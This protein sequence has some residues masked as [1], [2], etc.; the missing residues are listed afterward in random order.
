MHCPG[1][2]HASASFVPHLTRLKN[3]GTRRPCSIK[4]VGDKC[5]F[6]QPVQSASLAIV[7]G[8]LFQ[9][10]S[11]VLPFLALFNN[12]VETT[13][14]L[15]QDNTFMNATTQNATASASA[16]MKMPT[17]FSSL[18]AFIYSFSS[19]HDYAKLIVLGGAFETL[20]RLYAASYKSL[21][22][23]FFITATFESDDISYGEH[24]SPHPPVTELIQ[25]LEWMMFWLS[26]LPQFR[27]FRD[28]SVCTNSPSLED[29]AL[30]I[31]RDD[32]MDEALRRRTRP[33]Q[34][35]PSY[36]SSYWMWYKGTYIT[37][38]RTKEETRWYSEKATLEITSVCSVSIECLIP[39]SFLQ[40]LLP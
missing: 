10:T 3:H 6:F 34:Y 37:I 35:L 38:S 39:E 5:L 19:L 13:T 22:D 4:H 9:L 8:S 1:P 17:D 25:R 29:S 18:V 2:S 31:D 12:S 15:A 32:N 40:N 20:R 27:Q 24:S 7:M 11:V 30:E 33:V 16:P 23:R 14:M 28:F 36:T 21:M 26:S